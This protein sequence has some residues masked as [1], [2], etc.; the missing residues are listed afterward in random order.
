MT[1]LPSMLPRFGVAVLGGLVVAALATAPADAQRRPSTLN[2][3]CE[4]AKAFVKKRGSVTMYIGRGQAYDKF[5]FNKSQCQTGDNPYPKKVQ[6][7]DGGC[8]LRICFSPSLG[9]SGG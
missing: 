9:N 3:T 7:K 8:I 4:Q 5:I 6:T 2:F 1:T